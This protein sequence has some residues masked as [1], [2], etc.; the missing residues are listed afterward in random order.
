MKTESEILN[1]LAQ[2]CSLTERCLADV[3]KKLQSENLSAETEKR[4]IDRLLHDK[5]IDE[6]RFARS[7]VHDKFRF[8]R[9]G[10]I[11]ID[12]ELRL[13]G[14][15]QEVYCEAIDTIDDDAYTTTLSE[16][17]I[18]KKRTTK[19]RSSQELFQKLYR[20]AASRGFESH[21]IISTLK[22]MLK[23]IDDD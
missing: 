12:Y 13:K 7:F 22:K 4:I 6:N 2:Y 10:R 15:P 5:F 20:F 23:N 3:R 14:I 16:L 18:N 19:G 8:N 11:K 21:L 17:L 1:I 9:W